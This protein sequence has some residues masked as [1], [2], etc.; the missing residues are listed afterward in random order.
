VQLVDQHEQHIELAH[1]AEPRRHLAK[2][3]RQLARR[4]VFELQHRN[5]LAQTSRG[6]ARLMQGAD[7]TLLHRVEHA[8]KLIHAFCEQFRAGRGNGHDLGA[9]GSRSLPL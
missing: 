3:A 8:G 9:P 4:A 1:G 7:V 6:H 2:P 5:Q